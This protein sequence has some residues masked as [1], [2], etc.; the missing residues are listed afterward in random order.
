MKKKE[1][2]VRISSGESFWNLD[3][4]KATSKVSKKEWWMSAYTESHE[5]TWNHAKEKLGLNWKSQACKTSSFAWRRS[6]FVGWRG[7]CLL[8]RPAVR[9]ELPF[10]HS[11]SPTVV[12]SFCSKCSSNYNTTNIWGSLPASFHDPIPLWFTI[13]ARAAGS[14]AN[15]N[16]SRSSCTIP[17]AVFSPVWEVSELEWSCYALSLSVKMLSNRQCEGDQRE[18]FQFVLCILF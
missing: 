14:S 15:G 9:A 16:F 13:W 3:L 6:I 18:Q 7:R 12:K 1:F 2:E 4:S 11:S 17:A 5:V 10:W 8:L